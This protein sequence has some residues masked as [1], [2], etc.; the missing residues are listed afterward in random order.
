M[1]GW[2]ILVVLI[3][4]AVSPAAAEPKR[5]LLLHSFGPQ[6][7][8]WVFIAGQLREELF[9]QSPD[10]IDLY[11][12]SLEGA[13]FQQLDEQGPLVEYLAA[14]FGSRKPDLIITIGVPAAVFAQKYRAQLF[15]STPLVIG[16]AEQRG[17]N[18]TKLTSNDAPVSVTLDFTKWIENILEVMPDTKHIAWIV[19]GSPLERF[20]TEE[21][22][23]TSQPFS[24]KVSFEWFNDLPFEGMLKRIS[25]LPPHSA[26]FFVDLRVDGAG[27][28]LDRETV[29]PKLRAAT[30]A[31]IFSYVDN[32]L[33]QGI[34]GGPLMSSEEQGRRIAEAAV[35]ILRGEVPA[36][37]KIP[38]LAPGP[39]QYDWRELQHW[40]ISENRL[41]AGS[42]IRF[43]EP[44]MWQQYRSQ[45]ALVAAIILAQGA[46][47]S[48]LLFER[49]RRV[50]AELQSRQRSAE[51]AHINRVAMAGE[52]TATITH[53]LNQPL[54]A[55]LTN[56]ETAQ[57]LIKS[58]TPDL[59]EIDEILADIRRDDV[60][61]SEVIGRLRAQLKKVPVELKDIDLNEV[62]EETLRFLSA[63]AVAREVDLTSFIAPAS[64]PIKGDRILLQQVTM[65]LIVNAMDAMSTMLSTARR[66]TV[67]TAHDGSSACLSVSDVGPGIPVDQLKDVFEPFFTTKDAGMGMGLSIARTIVEAHRGQL[68][69]EN[70]AGR[71]ATFRI[72]LPLA[73]RAS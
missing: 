60:R 24:D 7:V 43:H 9:K 69:A 25:E 64:L 19:G 71:G 14:L 72:R 2:L 4:G 27:V 61:A 22:R 44:G 34:I 68:S 20:W 56:I 33:G 36:E 41:P 21:F 1:R 6:F 11:E 70:E 58:P 23:R 16:A 32:Y 5:V 15:P 66:I 62:A 40:N 53:E 54:G 10:K 37:L 13:R 39:P 63:L 49:R 73:K 8:P 59:L 35:R 3:F 65:N 17:I 12:A 50:H 46:L 52:L 67:S 31:P 45:I 48:G 42:I 18:Y 38:P 57:L 55:I 29:L 47:I 28:P 51:L 30:N 26:A